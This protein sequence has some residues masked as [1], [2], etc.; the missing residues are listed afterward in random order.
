M[1]PERDST[2]SLGSCF[3]ALLI[4][5]ERNS[6]SRWDGTFCVLVY[7]Y[8]PLSCSRCHWKESGNIL[9]APT[10]ESND[11]EIN[12]VDIVS[13]KNISKTYCSSSLFFS[14]FL[15]SV[16]SAS[17]FIKSFLYLW[18]ISTLEGKNKQNTN[19]VQTKPTYKHSHH[20][21]WT[22]FS[23]A[24]SSSSTQAGLL[25]ST[26]RFASFSTPESLD[27]SWRSFPSAAVTW[28]QPNGPCDRGHG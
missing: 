12:I 5:M 26:S 8:C 22:Y 24:S 23:S 16:A 21:T 13:H 28:K 9:L 4:S 2:A 18:V 7:V 25:S 1:S 3:R 20:L 17:L 15:V 27:S 6:S 11:H 14:F 10:L 19:I